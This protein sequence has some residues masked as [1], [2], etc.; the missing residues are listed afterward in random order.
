MSETVVNE[1]IWMKQ[2]AIR[3]A[4]IQ[5]YQFCILLCYAI[6]YGFGVSFF[7]RMYRALSSPLQFGLILWMIIG[8][9]C[10][11]LQL[12][13]WW[14]IRHQG[15][16]KRGL[17][18]G[19]I[20]LSILPC[21]D[22]LIPFC[23]RGVIFPTVL[24]GVRFTL[25]LFLS[26]FVWLCRKENLWSDVRVE[27]SIRQLANRYVCFH[28]A[29][30]L[31]TCLWLASAV[32]NFPILWGSWMAICEL[33]EVDYMIWL[34]FFGVLI[35]MVMA[36]LSIVVTVV[37]QLLAM[38]R[39]SDGI[40]W[41]LSSS[42]RILCRCMILAMTLP[43]LGDLLVFGPYFVYPIRVILGIILLI[44]TRRTI[45]AKMVQ[46]MCDIRYGV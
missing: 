29:F 3:W 41:Q 9:L 27:S 15:V 1:L 21:M 17:L 37:L 35:P 46:L 44:G 43:M 19:V 8:G 20:L 28:G 2:L 14:K 33:T 24:L 13:T 4:Y 26:C 12:M 25:V 30:V 16:I 38:V 42:Y 5:Q 7:G 6:S 32:M 11:Y 18:W 23:G 31:L 36:I 22:I 10:L 40:R 45:F 34:Q 39:N